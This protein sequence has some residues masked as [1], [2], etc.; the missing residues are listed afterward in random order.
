LNPN[1]LMSLAAKILTRENYKCGPQETQILTGLALTSDPKGID[2]MRK[3]T[4]FD[5]TIDGFC[6]SI[7][8]ETP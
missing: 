1:E 4:N 7:G 3:K 5:K 6:K 2:E 8:I